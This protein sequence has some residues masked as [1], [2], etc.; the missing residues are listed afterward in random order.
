MQRV[1]LTGKP[2]K[3]LGEFEIKG[4][5][6][7][8]ITMMDKWDMGIPKA[9]RKLKHN[10]KIYYTIYITETMLKRAKLDPY[11]ITDIYLYIKGCPT[12]NKYPYC[13]NKNLSILC[14]E[15]SAYRNYSNMKMGYFLR[16]ALNLFYESIRN[17]FINPR[18]EVI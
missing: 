6:A 15:I 5:K 13:D 12:L 18:G 17:R 1:I 3:L 4:S 7:Y 8:A 10:K 9:F 14:T 16:M 11:K 2:I